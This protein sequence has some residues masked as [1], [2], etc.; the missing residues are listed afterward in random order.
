MYQFIAIVTLPDVLEDDFNNL[1]PEQRLY[2]DELMHNGVVTGY[3]LSLDRSML[4][5]TLATSSKKKAQKAL[6]GFPI[7]EYIQYELVELMFHNSASF[8]FPAL[9][10]N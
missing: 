9:S 4:W 6:D 5:V 3:S 8:M 2:I 1:M 10:L 7:R